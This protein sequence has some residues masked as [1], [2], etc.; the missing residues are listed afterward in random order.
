MKKI[1]YGSNNNSRSKRKGTIELIEETET[2]D[3]KAYRLSRKLEKKQSRAT[4]FYG[5][6]HDLITVNANF[7]RYSADVLAS[8]CKPPIVSEKNNAIQSGSRHSRERSWHEVSMWKQE[9]DKDQ[10]T[11]YYFNAQTCES[12]WEA[13]EGFVKC[14]WQIVMDDV[15]QKIYYSNEKSGETSWSINDTQEDFQQGNPMNYVVN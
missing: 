2:E 3:E 10:E 7:R 12:I 1:K 4:D 11:Y 5:T 13:P 9:I 14:E 6:N 8:G 15:S